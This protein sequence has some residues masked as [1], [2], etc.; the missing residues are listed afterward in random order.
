[1]GTAI[2]EGKTYYVLRRCASSNTAEIWNPA[3]G[4]PYMMANKEF[5]STF[6]CLKVGS[7]RQTEVDNF[8]EACPL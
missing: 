4:D 7:Y 6:L 1:M 5:I 8:D 2:P 3:T